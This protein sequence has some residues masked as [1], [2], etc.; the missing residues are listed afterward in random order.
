M[1]Y[2]WKRLDY[3]HIVNSIAGIRHPF[4]Q[5]PLGTFTGWNLRAIGHGANDFCSLTGSYI[6]FA[7][8]A[9]ERIPLGDPRLSLEERYKN[10]NSY[11]IR[12]LFAALSLYKRGFLLKNDMAQIIKDAATGDMSHDNQGLQVDDEMAQ[13]IKEYS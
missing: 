11:L 6:P 7:K 3:P 9:E 4:L 12:V 13:I 8:A 10:H 5:V 1:K 2:E